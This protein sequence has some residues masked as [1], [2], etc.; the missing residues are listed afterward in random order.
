MLLCNIVHDDLKVAAAAS[1][2][3][4][5]TELVS[6]WVET[7]LAFKSSESLEASLLNCSTQG[8]SLGCL[9]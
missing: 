4:I 1:S 5:N 2:F 8:G 6:V 3:S 9:L 7:S